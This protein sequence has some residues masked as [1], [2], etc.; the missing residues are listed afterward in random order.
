MAVCSEF[1]PLWSAALDNGPRFV[2]SPDKGQVNCFQVD[3]FFF[4]FGNRVD[5][6]SKT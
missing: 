6:S 4:F 2:H 3:F 5:I 1:V